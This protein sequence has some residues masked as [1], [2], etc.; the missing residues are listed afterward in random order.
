MGM[1]RVQEGVDKWPVLSMELPRHK[2][3]SRTSSKALRRS[4]P[5]SRAK[6]PPPMSHNVDT[7]QV[8]G[9]DVGIACASVGKPGQ[10]ALEQ[11]VQG[12]LRRP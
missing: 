6:W 7:L 11:R 8:E 5:G 12:A 2:L 9:D 4:W 1:A 10:C 3:Q